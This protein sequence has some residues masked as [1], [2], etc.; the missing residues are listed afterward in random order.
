MNIG[1]NIMLIIIHH[2]HHLVQVATNISVTDGKPR[3]S[4]AERPQYRHATLKA[5]QFAL[6]S[7]VTTQ[8]VYGV[9]NL[10][11][12]QLPVNLLSANMQAF[13]VRW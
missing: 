2:H 1:L 10:H 13:E 6:T 8:C 11:A 4:Q 3:S 7:A 12:E 5:V 9:V